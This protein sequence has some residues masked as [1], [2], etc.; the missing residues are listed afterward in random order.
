MV[1]Y[2][3]YQNLSVKEK[4]KTRELFN[5]LDNH[6]NKGIKLIENSI[7]K[8]MKERKELNKKFLK[9]EIH[10]EY[11]NK[12]RKYLTDFIIKFFRWDI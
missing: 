2:K 3:F 6:Y 10:L 9:N 8:V 12:R 5:S 4:K 11:W 7:L 1:K